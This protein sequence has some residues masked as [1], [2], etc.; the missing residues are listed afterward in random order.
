MFNKIIG[1]EKKFRIYINRKFV[2]FFV[3]VMLN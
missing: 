2:Y 3:E 1:K